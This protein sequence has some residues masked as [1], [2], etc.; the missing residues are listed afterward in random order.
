MQ[1]GTGRALPVRSSAHGAA[2]VLA[3]AT[4]AGRHP[5][6]APHGMYLGPLAPRLSAAR[7]RAPLV[8]TPLALRHLRATGARADQG[9]R[10]CRPGSVTPSGGAGR[11]IRPV[12]GVG[13]KGA[14]GYDAGKKVTERKRHAL[15]AACLH[16]S[17]GGAAL[18]A[19]SRHPWPFLA[20][21]FTDYAYA[22]VR[23][24]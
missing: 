3:D 20:R 2:P 9:P 5:L 16:D 23:V 15:S 24:A 11:S 1:S 17:R 21:C 14:N 8:P 7:D 22:E 10:A 13:V 19:M 12:G 18:Q 4:V 6:R